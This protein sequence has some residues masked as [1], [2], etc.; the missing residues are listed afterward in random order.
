MTSG[1]DTAFRP[2]DGIRVVEMSH[3]IMGPSCGMFLAFLGAEVIKV[4]P[5]EGDK[6]RHLTGMGRGF[7]P[8]FNRGKKSVALDLKTQAGRDALERLLETADVFVENFRDELLARMGLSPDALREKHP[9]L[10]VAS[11]KG[12]LHGP[13]ENR[14]AMDEVVQMMTGMAYM[15]GPTGR[16][17]RIGSS[18]NDIMGGLFG[19]FAVLGALLQRG[20]DGKG[21]AVR[22]GLFE[23]CLLLV[24]QHMVQFDIEGRE[25]PPMPEREF[26][27]PIY[28]IFETADGRQIFVGA[29]TEGQWVTLCDILGLQELKDD[30][31]L[32]KRMDQI[33]ARDWTIPIVARAVAT[34]G[35]DELIGAFESAGIPFAPIHRP[36]EMYDDP[37]VNRPGGLLT[38]ALPEGRTFRAPGFPFAVDG[39]PSDT[40]PFDLPEVGADT[41]AILSVLGLAETDI[42]AASGASKAKVA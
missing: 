20:K 16:P 42:R 33:E 12:F 10:I 22:V 21:H 6:T 39:G 13:Y 31:R 25:A 1:T 18:A 11:C 27:W 9:K 36:A 8:T 23:N 2:L 26:S 3:M 28:D 40:G 41:D 17:L 7:F 4:E 29:V 32:Q 34:R 30:P 19:A 37:H 14:T 15:T 35:F 5:P 38:S 24:A